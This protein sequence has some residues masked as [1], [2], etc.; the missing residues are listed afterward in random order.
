MCSHSHCCPEKKSEIKESFSWVNIICPALILIFTVFIDLPKNLSIILYLFAYLWAGYDI[1]LTSFKNILKLDFF[2]ENFLMSIATIGAFLIGEYPEAVMVVL[3]YKIGETLQDKAV[4]KSRNLISKLTNINP[5][6]AN[7]CIN[8]ELVKTDPSKVNIGDVVVIKSGEKIPL[9]GVIVEGHAN[10]DMSLLTGE[11][12]PLYL[13]EGKNVFSGSIVVDGYL[14]VKVEKKYTDSTVSKILELV[15]HASEKKANSEKFITKFAKIYT[16]IVVILALI[17]AIIPPLFFGYDFIVCLKR[18]LV[19]LVISCPCA[20]VISI[21]LSFFSGIGIAAKQGILIKGSKYIEVLSKIKNAVFDKTGTL[22]KGQF[23]IEKVASLDNSV[24]EKEILNIMC[25]LENCSNHPLAMSILKACN[26]AI[27]KGDIKNI[28]EISGKGIKAILDNQEVLIGSKALLNMNN[29]DTPSVNEI[30]TIVYLAINNNCVGYV[31]LFDTLKETSKK[32][33]EK[34]K[35]LK[36]NTYI[37]SG[38]SDN[39]VRKIADELGVDNYFSKLFPKDKVEKIENIIKNENKNETTLFVGDGINDAPV[40]KRADIGIS[41]GAL[42]S[43]IAIEASDVV[44]MDDNLEKISK[45][46]EISKKTMAIAKQNIVFAITVKV[47]FLLLSM[48]GFMTMWGAVFSDV[49][50]TFL[51]VLNCLR[52]IR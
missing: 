13:D 52:I 8:N 20:L 16:P 17:L 51:A 18:A 25:Q 12:L 10:V 49:G 40:L 34:L 29:I 6:Y 1:L 45:A 2:D 22:T 41:M 35:K 3:L 27:K 37:L 33:I 11:S 30:G 26:F 7:V 5:Q 44:I 24:S 48:L 32:S 4:D 28:D 31:V 14:K 36:I 43:D 42:G 9:D 15:E 46:I 19:F 39:A 23:D 21:P 47:L 38:D 50:V